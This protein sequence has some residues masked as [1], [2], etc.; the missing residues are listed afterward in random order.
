MKIF[1]PLQWGNITLG[2]CINEFE[3]CAFR[4]I[5]K[6]GL[7]K[8]AIAQQ[9]AIP[10][11]W[12]F[13]LQ[14]DSML[15]RGFFPIVFSPIEKKGLFSSSGNTG[16]LEPETKAISFEFVCFCFL[17]FFFNVVECKKGSR[18]EKS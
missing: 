18:T 5:F 2:V 13:P 7:R 14:I 9:T 10:R 16:N 1:T 17:F 8:G 6:R 15:L 11:S 4:L 12:H 3:P